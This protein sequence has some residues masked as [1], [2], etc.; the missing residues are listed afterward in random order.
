MTHFCMY[1]LYLFNLFGAKVAEKLILQL[2]I[3]SCGYDWKGH[4]LIL[5][6]GWPRERPGAGPQLSPSEARSD[7]FICRVGANCWLLWGRVAPVCR[8][9][10]PHAR[11][12]S[13]CPALAPGPGNRLLG[14]SKILSR[15]AGRRLGGCLSGWLLC[16]NWSS[17]QKR[18]LF[19]LK[20]LLLCQNH[21]PSS[22]VLLEREVTLAG[23]SEASH[24]YKH[25]SED[26]PASFPMP[27]R[28]TS[29]SSR[30][31]GNLLGPPRPK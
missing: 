31:G 19:K 27:A 22:F 9:K 2:E 4:R 17:T 15:T 23:W 16:A 26:T 1:L 3:L 21:H 7:L 8:G 12:G 28:G 20:R 24:P 13:Q 5:G 10:G 30:P 6:T 25:W 18:L 29:M 14:G 11:P